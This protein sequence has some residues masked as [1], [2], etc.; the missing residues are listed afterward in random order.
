MRP[1]F[2]EAIKLG[3]IHYLTKPADIDMIIAAFARGEAPPLS[4]AP[5]YEAPTLARA[6]W[7]HIHRVLD[8]CGG[9]VTKAA[10]ALGM[11]RRTLQRK[12]AV[13]PPRR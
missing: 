2:L 4:E 9:N 6:E 5:E 13:S 7:E 8:D 11:H 12:L 1:D 10:K 3:A